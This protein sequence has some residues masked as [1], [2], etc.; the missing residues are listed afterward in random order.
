MKWKLRAW[1]YRASKI[2]VWIER[3]ILLR[4]YYIPVWHWQLMA[5]AYADILE[6]DRLDRLNE[7]V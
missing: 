7:V 6:K 3:K 2:L 5:W 1:I 4:R